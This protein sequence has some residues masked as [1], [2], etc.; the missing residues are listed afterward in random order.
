MITECDLAIRLVMPCK[1]HNLSEDANI[2]RNAQNDEKYKKLIR[3]L[4]TKYEYASLR[5]C[6]RR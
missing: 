2:T 3:S 1:K 6:R 5:N 4:V